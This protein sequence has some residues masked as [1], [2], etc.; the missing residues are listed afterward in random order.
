MRTSNRHIDI[1]VV[2]PCCNEEASIPLFLKRL[3][4]VMNEIDLKYE[5]IIVDDGSTDESRELLQ[6][7]EDFYPLHA[8][9]LSRNYGQQAALL[10][11]IHQA[12]GNAIV[13]ID[14][15][16]QQPPE[17]I[18]KLIN[19]WHQGAN[20]VME[21]SLL[22]A[23]GC[24][25]RIYTW[26]AYFLGLDSEKIGLSTCIVLGLMARQNIHMPRCWSWHFGV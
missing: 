23:N 25:S 3:D 19:R 16:L 11:G 1:S 5:V 20:V 22:Y 7:H 21:I 8:V 15:D 14:L 24:R 9:F 6:Y 26:E 18:A 12:K 17:V 4:K 13:T 10:A 2:A